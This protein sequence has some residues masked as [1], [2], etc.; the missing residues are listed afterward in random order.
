MPM[1]VMRD[2]LNRPF[3]LCFLGWRLGFR[4]GGALSWLPD[5]YQHVI[6]LTW[7]TVACFFGGHNLVLFE[8][9]PSW[10]IRDP[11]CPDCSWRPGKKA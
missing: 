8:V 2:H 10:G 6:A 1:A 11:A 5:R 7:N 9:P 3:G 4:G